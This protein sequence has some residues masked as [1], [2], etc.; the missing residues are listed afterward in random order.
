MN[1]EDIKQNLLLA[2][3]V[4]FLDDSQPG[5]TSELLP[6]LVSN[7]PNDTMWEHLRY[8][9][10]T[11]RSFSFA[12]AFITEDA[13][14]P[15]KVVLADLAVKGISGR[16]LTSN[17]LAFNQPKVF[18]EL[19][20]IPNITV[21]IVT[22]EGFH[23]KGYL[24]EHNDYYSMIIGS[25]N[26]TRA[27]LLHNVEWNLHF[28]ALKDGAV[29]KQIMNQ[30]DIEWQQAVE[31]TNQWIE[32]YRHVYN[33]TQQ[34][35][36]IINSVEVKEKA[37]IVPN[38]MQTEALIELAKLRATN[39]RRGLVISA[40]G[41]GKTFLAALDVKQVNPNKMLFVVHR[42]QILQKALD[43]FKRVLGGKDSDYGI[44]SGNRNERQAKY[45]FATLQTL[46]KTDVLKRFAPN[47]FDYLLI[48]EAHRSGSE[49]YR[50][51]LDYFT[52]AFCLGMTATPERTDD[53]SIYQLFDYNIAYE[54]R[55]QDALEEQM[56]TPF[57]YVGL[58]DYEYDGKLIDDK[59][60]LRLLVAKERVSYVLKQLEYYGYSG[61]R[62]HGLIFC[63]N[64]LESKEIA[65]L[66]AKN[67]HPAISL[68]GS[69]SIAR[70]NQVVTQ[71]E[72]G[73]IEYIVTVDIFNE[74]IDIPCLN[75]VVM[76][77]NTQSS[78]VFI[79]Q[80]GRG[81]RK[82]IGKEFLTIIDFIGNY[83]NNY[84]IPTALTGD[85][86][87]SKD[88]AR[89][90]LTM[91]PI[92]GLSTINFTEV[93]RQRIYEAI[94]VAKLDA[95]ATLRAD[96]QE[97]KQRLGRI[98]L[99]LD[100]QKYG[101]I[102]A[103]VFAENNQLDSYASFLIKMKEQVKLTE[104][105]AKVLSF[106]TKELVNGMRRHEL[107]LLRLLLE[108][109]VTDKDFTEA[110]QQNNCYLDAAVLQSVDDIL[111]LHFFDIKS[112]RE[113]K[114]EKY[115]KQ[116]IVEHSNG[117]YGFN[118]VINASL[119]GISD[120]KRMFM[121]VIATGL[122]KANNFNAK[123]PFAYYQKYSRK[124]VC[125]LLNW[126]KDVS[127]PMYGYR[128]GRD[129]CPIFITY[130]KDDPTKN[131]SARYENEFFNTGLIKWYTRSPRHIDSKEVQQL[132]ERDHNG[133]FKVQIQ[134]FLKKS[135]AEGKKFYYLGKAQ[136]ALDSVKEQ[137]ISQAGKRPKAVVSLNLK[138]NEPI[139]YGHFINITK[140]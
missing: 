12:L 73:Q 86:S 92:L 59:S 98:P 110:L 43:S 119:Q 139:K 64:V 79:Q 46:S 8:E 93:A 122:Y 65:Q 10:Q 135:D 42:E 19:L 100:F 106:A 50:R 80:L 38:K 17:Y 2:A 15:L 85:I 28:S 128:V 77:R 58:Q 55:L 32:E 53:F 22:Q 112:G 83:K 47:Q 140:K 9:L 45:L 88:S 11:C 4:G 68:D 134:L 63:S 49:T 66:L 27:A 107:L 116:A 14:T 37:P 40:T 78:I 138:L 1:N 21:R 126:S 120:F 24:F 131:R 87:R 35:R 3:T 123:Q 89:A 94:Q 111:S 72:H 130:E 90:D 60:P 129:A 75:Q 127:A 20:K 33:D 29:T 25:S 69:D 54:I 70:R 57:H 136:A 115:G 18:E 95:F 91:Q 51:I 84:L 97:L 108:K 62:V 36:T 74:G 5:A 71:L 52:P 113:N 7:Q 39:E 41:T 121:D 76:L 61:K 114:A 48:D 16:I 81:L 137:M 105:E 124:D 125:R 118:S 101:G 104:Y 6:Q 34:K 99:L 31:L 44:L 133:D 117:K 23:A 102:D 26:L 56:L 132:L 13:L 30:L 82:Y 67:G 96:Y 103:E 109:E